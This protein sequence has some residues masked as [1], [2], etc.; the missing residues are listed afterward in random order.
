MTTEQEN[1]STWYDDLMTL[2][3]KKQDENQALKKVQ[4][5]LESLRNEKNSNDQTF[6]EA[7]QT[8]H[9]TNDD[10]PNINEHN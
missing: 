10:S 3:R 6:P 7:D 4:E 8:E 9:P 1:K 2:I 5:S